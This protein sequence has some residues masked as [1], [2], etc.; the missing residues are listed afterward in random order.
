MSQLVTVR[1]SRKT[2]ISNYKTTFL[3]FSNYHQVD[4]VR[5]GSDNE[6]IDQNV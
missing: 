4:F 1:I 3:F 2:P 5:N 6:S